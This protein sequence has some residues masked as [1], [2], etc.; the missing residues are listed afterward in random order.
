[1]GWTAEM[2][3]NRYPKFYSRGGRAKT[4][5]IYYGPQEKERVVSDDTKNRNRVLE[6]IENRC[7]NGEDL[8][9]IVNEIAGRPEIK[10][11]FAYY[12]K[13]GVVTPLETIFKN[14]YLAK[15][16]NREKTDKINGIGE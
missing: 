12:I 10:E 11:Q 9:T 13:N 3:K 15:Q 1:M 14:W 8:D 7:K 16:R 2:Q 4:N 5:D 6:E